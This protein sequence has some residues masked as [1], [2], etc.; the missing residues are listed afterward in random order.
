MYEHVI[1]QFDNKSNYFKYKYKYKTKFFNCINNA[2]KKINK[3][4]IKCLMFIFMLFFLNSWYQK[5]FLL[6]NINYAKKE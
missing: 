5:Q 6:I 1:S 4:K 3:E 2:L